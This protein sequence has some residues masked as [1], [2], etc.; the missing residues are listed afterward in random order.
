MERGHEPL[1]GRVL[2][3]VVYSDEDELLTGDLAGRTTSFILIFIRVPVL[4]FWDTNQPYHTVFT[5]TD[6]PIRCV[7]RT[8][9]G[10]WLSSGRNKHSR[11][12]LNEL[13]GLCTR[14]TNVSRRL[15]R[16]T[17][18]SPALSRHHLMFRL[19]K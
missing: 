12:R 10:T 13:I 3:S 18:P 1:R 17:S 11:W 9:D 16:L 19:H 15:F 8:A 7:T 2:Y 4:P 5:R 14:P 6:Q